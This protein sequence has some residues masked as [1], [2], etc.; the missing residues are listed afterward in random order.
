MIKWQT[1]NINKKVVVFQQSLHHFGLETPFF[2]P[3]RFDANAVATRQSAIYSLKRFCFLIRSFS[4]DDDVFLFSSAII[5]PPPQCKNGTWN[6]IV[7]RYYTHVCYCLLF[8]CLFY[9]ALQYFLPENAEMSFRS[10]SLIADNRTALY[11]DLYNVY[12]IISNI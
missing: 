9:L 2:E 4:R 12:R 10:I 1:Y 3:T 8:V 7:G 6:S 11:S 5:T